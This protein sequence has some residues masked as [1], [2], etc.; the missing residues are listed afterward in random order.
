MA[1]ETL[2][3]L[4]K[5]VRGKTLKLIDGL[6]DDQARFAAAGLQNSILWHAGHAW[7]VN[8]ALGISA[9]TGKPPVYP[10]AWFETFSWKSN[11]ALVKTW[12]KL[13]EVADKLREQQQ[14]LASGIESL[15]P[16]QLSQITGDPAKARTVRYSI[17]HGLHDEAIH[18]GEIWLLKKMSTRK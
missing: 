2:L 13:S 11:P 10:D 9:I 15:S 6:T 1:D 16:A 14:Q 5:D 12:P 3:M 17:M 18:Q 7:I 4:L 8:E